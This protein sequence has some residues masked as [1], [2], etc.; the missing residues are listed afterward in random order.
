MKIFLDTSTTRCRNDLNASCLNVTLKSPINIV[1]KIYNKV[2]LE[3][4]SLPMLSLSFEEKLK[5]NLLTLYLYK[6]AELWT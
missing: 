3:I 5:C 2:P 1:I 4:K 6:L